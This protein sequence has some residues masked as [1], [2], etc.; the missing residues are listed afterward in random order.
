MERL[1]RRSFLAALAAAPVI[2]TMPAWLF[3]RRHPLRIG[4]TFTVSG[5]HAIDPLTG[6]ALPALRVFKIVAAR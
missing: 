3:D 5:V 4:D 1:S 2:A 6:R